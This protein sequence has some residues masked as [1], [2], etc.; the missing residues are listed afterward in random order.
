MN[1]PRAT[2]QVGHVLDVLRQMPAESVH[3]VVTSPPYWGLRDYKLKPQVWGGDPACAHEW[4]G[5]FFGPEGY[6][7]GQKRKWQHGSTRGDNP[8]GW[9]RKT[10]QGSS[11]VQCGAWHGSLGLEPTPDLYVAHL[12]HV[13]REVR[14]VLRK[15]GTLWLNMGDCYASGMR[16]FYDD[17]R[18]KYATAR[19][20]DMRPPTPDGV[21]PKDLVG[22]PWMVAFALRADGWWLRSDIIWSKPNPMPESVTDR[23]TRAHEYLFLLAKSGRYFYDAD[24]IREPFVEGTYKRVLQDTFDEQEGGPKDYAG[25]VNENRSARRALEHLAPKIRAAARN[26]TVDTPHHGGRRQA[27]EPG[28]PNAFHLFGRNKRTVWEIPTEPFPEAHFATFPQ[29]LVLPCVQA[30]TSERG[31]CP[32]CGAPWERVASV[33]YHNDT[34]RSGRPAEGNRVKSDGCEAEVMGYAVRTRRLSETVEWRPTCAC[35]VA[36][37]VPATV[38]DPF[39]GSGTTLVVAV[40]NGRNAIGI[41]LQAAYLPMMQRRLAVLEVDLV[42]PV[43]V[44]VIG[45]G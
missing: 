12:V 24:A 8:E 45:G 42:H 11:C 29:A 44:R 20:H 16:S 10:P 6:A 36:E 5:V 39:V 30:G 37:T 23:P 7:S 25:G 33:S 31:V 1:G 13:F 38:L 2:I 22:I 41:D 27:P 9:Q 28:E 19:A 3:C 17:D 32:R 34:T 4:G 14:R 26:K 15:D 35:G 40:K 21:K 18:H 43:T